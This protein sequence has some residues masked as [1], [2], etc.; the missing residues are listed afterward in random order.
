[1]T[2]KLWAKILIGLVLG[3]ITGVI[4]GPSAI[5]LKPLGTIFLGLIN[6]IILPLVLSSMAVGITSIHDPK[7]L[8][9]VGIKTLLLYLG[10]TLAAIFIGM[11]FA[12]GFDVGLGLNL[13][14]GVTP[15]AVVDAPTIGTILLSLVPSN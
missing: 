10:T 6:M 9:R 15:P 12:K 7:K 2:M 13:H 3:A 5:Y 4:I 11:A 8:G 1:M 14:Q